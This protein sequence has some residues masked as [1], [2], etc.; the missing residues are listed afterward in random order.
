MEELEILIAKMKSAP[1]VMVV[2]VAQ[3]VVAV[4]EAMPV[5]EKLPH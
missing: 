2:R 3:E 5:R 4:R 1:V